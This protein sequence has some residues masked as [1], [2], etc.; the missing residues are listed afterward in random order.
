MC[1]GVGREGASEAKDPCDL[2]QRELWGLGGD[3][4]GEGR[5]RGR[6]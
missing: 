2:K 5:D 4:M 6:V 1:V 3:E